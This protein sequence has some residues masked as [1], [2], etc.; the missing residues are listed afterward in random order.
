MKREKERVRGKKANYWVLRYKLIIL[1]K[2]NKLLGFELQTIS[3]RNLKMMQQ[4]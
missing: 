1:R 4:N 3:L 2:E